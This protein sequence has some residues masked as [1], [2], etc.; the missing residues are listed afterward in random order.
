MPKLQYHQGMQTKLLKIP[1]QLPNGQF[2]NRTSLPLTLTMHMRTSLI[3]GHRAPKN[4]RIHAC[5]AT[6][7]FCPQNG[8]DLRFFS[9][10]G[11]PTRPRLPA[12]IRTG[13]V[14]KSYFRY[15][16]HSVGDD[17]EKHTRESL[18][19]EVN[20][21][22]GAAPFSPRHVTSPAADVSKTANRSTR[23]PKTPPRRTPS[24]L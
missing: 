5:Y 6:D 14:L 24:H 18:E 17:T 20:T 10:F 16:S 7:A 2:G 8:P 11:A 21:E 9:F 1:L 15:C 4:R 12:K 19:L 13:S 22:K 3:S 23:P